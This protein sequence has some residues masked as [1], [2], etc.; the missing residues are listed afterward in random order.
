[1]QFKPGFRFSILDGFILVVALCTG[2]FVAFYDYK[3]SVLIGFVV[4]HFFLFCN[5]VRMSRVPELIW[6][7]SF[8]ALFFC[9]IKLSL[10][11]FNSALATS[12]FFTVILVAIE[13]RKPSYHGIYW[14]VLNPLAPYWAPKSF[15]CTIWKI[16]SLTN[17]FFYIYRQRGLL[18]NV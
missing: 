6:A 4:L 18:K 5:I 12:L 17:Y 7:T 9:H 10:L 15:N 11:S 3:Y 8:L 13:L 1:M 2:I 14:K 16:N